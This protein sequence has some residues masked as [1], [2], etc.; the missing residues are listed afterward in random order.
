MAVFEKHFTL[1]EA[2]A[3]LPELRDLIVRLKAIRD[4][5]IVD[6][7]E[8]LPVL[9]A[10]HANGGGRQAA[11]YAGDLLQLNEQLRRL[12]SLGVQL[13]DVDKGLVDFPSWRGDDE[14]FLCWHLG[15]DAVRY[16]HTLEAGFNG[17][18]AL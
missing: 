8:A 3:L 14:V 15:E 5:L 11:A 2:N 4:H 1:D 9:R 16:W 12:A 6:W 13:K 10:A 7:Q 17:R 18:R